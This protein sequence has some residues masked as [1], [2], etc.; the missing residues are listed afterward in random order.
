[1]SSQKRPIISM[2]DITKVYTVGGEEV[3]ALDGASLTI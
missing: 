3:R 2:T 1:M